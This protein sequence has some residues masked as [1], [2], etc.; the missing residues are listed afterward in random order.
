M[1]AC[2]AAAAR[3]APACVRGASAVGAGVEGGHW[4]FTH[5]DRQSVALLDCG[6]LLAL[7]GL[8]AL[9]V[10][11]LNSRGTPWMLAPTRRGPR[12]GL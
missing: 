2:A 1:T 11:D 9:L 7:S 3:D 8:P 6:H 12:R 5:F 10:H 4:S